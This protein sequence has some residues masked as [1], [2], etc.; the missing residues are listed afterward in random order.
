MSAFATV[1]EL[2]IVNPGFLLYTPVAL[3]PVQDDDL[4]FERSFL[5][6]GRPPLLPKSETGPP[7]DEIARS[8]LLLASN[9]APVLLCTP[10]PSLPLEPLPFLLLLLLQLLGGP[11]RLYLPRLPVLTFTSRLLSRRRSGHAPQ[12]G[13]PNNLYLARLAILPLASSL[14]L[15]VAILILVLAVTSQLV[16]LLVLLG[17]GLGRGGLGVRRRGRT[18]TRRG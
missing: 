11:R 12:L 4:A 5:R 13:G 17:A 14:L 1:L 18:T 3:G 9:C 8:S 6:S 15:A 2:A 7:F 10:T 16:P